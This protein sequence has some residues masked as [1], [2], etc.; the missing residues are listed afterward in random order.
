MRVGHALQGFLAEKGDLLIASTKLNIFS[1]FALEVDSEDVGLPFFGQPAFFGITSS[2][3]GVLRVFCL[4]FKCLRL[5]GLR[6]FAA[7]FAKT[8][9][10]VP[11]RFGS[12]GLRREFRK[13]VRRGSPACFGRFSQL[14]QRDSME[15]N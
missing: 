5:L 10:D 8:M 11:G 15:K 12:V 3:F 1:T 13:M 4:K 9:K 14:S 2:R 6:W 7:L